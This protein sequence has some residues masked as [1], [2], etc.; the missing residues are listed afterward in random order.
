MKKDKY[1]YG[2]YNKGFG[3]K[4]LIWFWYSNWEGSSIVKRKHSLQII[5]FRFNRV[6]FF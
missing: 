4:G 5:C 6:I 3:V 2:G 1:Y